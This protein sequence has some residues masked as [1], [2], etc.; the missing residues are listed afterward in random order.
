MGVYVMKNKTIIGAILVIFILSGSILAQEIEQKTEFP[1]LTLRQK[2]QRATNDLNLFIIAGISYVK[3]QGKPVTDFGK[4]LGELFAPNWE[5]VKGKGV[6]GFV[7][8]IYK[9]WQV[10]RGFKLRLLSITK[11]SIEAKIQDIGEASLETWIESG[12]TKEDYFRFYGQLMVTIT[13]YL[14]LE[15]K[16]EVEEDWIYFTVTEKK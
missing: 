5:E 12:I 15:Y 8:G 10:L 3:S 9:N 14:G 7:E 13:D 1:Y 4:Y 2:W 16:Q 6:L 11:T